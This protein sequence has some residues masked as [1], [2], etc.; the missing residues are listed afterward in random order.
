M[1]KKSE[2]PKEEAG[3]GERLKELRN[4][5]GMTQNELAAKCEISQ[6][7]IA[8]LEMGLQEPRW[9]TVKLI[10]KALGVSCEEFRK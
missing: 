4:K 9:V 5:K 10:C 7:Q 2:S 6:T 3:F 8:R 1:T